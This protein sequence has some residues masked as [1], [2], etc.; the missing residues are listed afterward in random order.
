MFIALVAYNLFSWHVPPSSCFHCVCRFQVSGISSFRRFQTSFC[1][2]LC[3]H[4]LFSSRVSL[5]GFLSLYSAYPFQAGLFMVFSAPNLVFVVCVTLSL[6]F[7]IFCSYLFSMSLLPFGIVFHGV[8]LLLSSCAARHFG[9]VFHI[10]Y[11]LPSV[12]FLYAC[13]FAYPVVCRVLYLCSLLLTFSFPQL[14]PVF[15]NLSSLFLC[16]FVNVIEVTHWFF[17]VYFLGPFQFLVFHS[18]GILKRC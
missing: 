2:V 1:N 16:L 13:P 7:G 3:P 10:F 11:T 15:G 4:F 6:V 9:L 17:L 18:L 14:V 8:L 5:L 12:F